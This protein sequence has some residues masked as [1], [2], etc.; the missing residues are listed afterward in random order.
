MLELRIIVL[1]LVLF[2][3][4]AFSKVSL[5]AGLVK[6]DIIVVYDSAREAS[7]TVTPVHM[8]A[9]FPLNHLGY[10]LVYHDLRQGLPPDALLADAAGILSWFR[11]E[12]E[13]PELYLAWLLR[14][15]GRGIKVIVLGSVGAPLTVQTLDMTNRLFAT[16]GLR[17]TEDFISTAVDARVHTLDRTMM[18]FER[19]ID[20]VPNQHFLVEQRGDGARVLLDYT[21]TV[22][23]R[24]RRSVVAAIGPGGAYVTHGF[25]LHGDATTGG[26]RWLVDP[27]AFFT[28]AL[29]QPAFP[30]PDTTTVSGRRLYFSHV[31]GDGWNNGV[32][33]ERYRAGRGAGPLTAQPAGQDGS[34]TVPGSVRSSGITAA[35]MMLRDLIAPYPD[36]P[37]SVGLV[38]DDT[39]AELGGGRRA[40]AA[41]RQIYALPQVEVASHT[42][43]HPFLWEFFERY[44]RAR[45]YEVIRQNERER[46][47]LTTR[48]MEA[49][50]LAD[51]SDAR[52]NR[53]MVGGN[54]APRAF[55]RD[56]FSIARE[57]THALEVTQALAPAHK[58]VAIYLWSGN[59][60]PFEAI[61]RATR[62]AG[63]RNINGGDTR[64]DA[65]HPSI[66]Y[67][68]PIGRIVGDERQIY[69]VNSN[70]NT[71]T[72]L[73]TGHFHGFRQLRET[74]ERTERPRRLKGANVYYHTYSAERRASLEAVRSHLD[75]ARSAPLAPIRAS[76]YAAIADG[77]YS[78]RIAQIGERQ[79]TIGARDGLQTLRFDQ[80]DGLVPDLER[81]LG[82]L[83]SNSHAGALYVA[84]DAAV[85]QAR[86]VMGPRPE[87]PAGFA[88]ASLRESRWQLRGLTRAA[89]GLRFAA[90][91][92]GKG[93]FVFE[94][95]PPRAV[96]VIAARNGQDLHRLAAT[97]D[98]A[99]TL[100][101][102]LPVLAYEPLDVT[103]R[104]VEG[105]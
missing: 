97:V 69:A 4:A 40:Q 92:Y 65:Q 67:V 20:P 9:E 72:N 49:I 34:V 61:V 68:A 94:G 23:G 55:L 37:V 43:T 48:L 88:Q 30:I 66:A 15:S 19:Q 87:R 12:L 10:R 62:Q 82:V 89:C 46:R 33:I 11:Y 95:L 79:W 24:E 39:D 1:L 75:W 17:M 91:G 47:D 26:A 27:F 21:L 100:A 105:Q 58:P 102:T 73:W 3:P 53:Y 5:A 54:H 28:A 14:M 86:L 35:E 8:R 85:P 13:E 31:D 7:P 2:G 98:L 56:P 83:G 77:F 80:A 63:L 52:R 44:D 29:G 93:E 16:F 90:E 22:G 51:A 59:T 6:R 25:I 70:E 103:I 78:T 57:V 42:C 36:L 104:C 18:E 76:H 41:A 101:F 38:A 64:F 96:E 74:L 84:L 32:Q 71:Y 81:S 99:G 45:E 50:G 60:R